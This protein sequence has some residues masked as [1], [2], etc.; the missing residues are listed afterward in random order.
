MSNEKKGIVQFWKDYKFYFLTDKNKP[1]YIIYDVK[2]K[3]HIIKNSEGFKETIYLNCINNYI[4]KSELQ[5]LIRCDRNNIKNPFLEFLESNNHILNID[6]LTFEPTNKQIITKNSRVYFNEYNM[7]EIYEKFNSCKDKDSFP[8]IKNL[9]MNLAGQ[10]LK[11][12]DWLLKRIAITIQQPTLKIP[13]Y[14]V[15]QGEPGSGK[16]T[17]FDLI[18]TKIFSEKYCLGTSV[19]KLTSRFNG[20]TTNKIWAMIDEAEASKNTN[21]TSLDS[22]IKSLTGNKKKQVEKKGQDAIEVDD[23][24]NYI[25]CS[26]KIDLGLKLESNDRRAVVLGFSKPLKEGDFEKYV[27]NIPL[28][29]INFASYLN[30][31]KFNPSEIIKP[32]MT[33][34]KRNLINLAK[35]NAELFLDEIKSYEDVGIELLFGIFNLNKIL[36]DYI[37][38]KSTKRYIKI[39][40][41]YDLYEGYCKKNNKHAVRKEFFMP[42]IYAKTGLHSSKQRVKIGKEKTITKYFRC[43]DLEKFNY[44]FGLKDNKD[45]NKDYSKEDVTELTED[46]K[47]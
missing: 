35:S 43:F 1:T 40:L 12:Y 42:D 8:N 33:E 15:F 23:F 31:L 10:D 4:D 44:Y 45:V 3:F 41:L 24:L 29:L 6:D 22:T 17:L 36:K 7:P 26:N 28:E 9:I 13:T 39:D 47:Y 2:R 5:D 27:K 20:E 16:N 37:I 21:N 38:P 30:N 32:I 18:F 11:A 14:I 46:Y 34:G 19:D 25:F